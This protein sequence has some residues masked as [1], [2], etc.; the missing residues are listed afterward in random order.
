[1]AWEIGGGFG[2][3]RPLL[4]VARALAAHGHAPVFALRN[5]VEPRP[6]FAQDSFPILQAP[7]WHD[8]R[9][10][11]S[12][13]FQAASFA[14]VLAVRGWERVED[15]APQLE[16]WRDL[17]D[18]VQPRLV[19]CDHSPTL[20]LAAYGA[21]PVVQTGSWFSLP[22]LDGDSFPRMISAAEPVI[23]QEQLLAVIQQVQR[24]R[25]A[26]V[27]ARLPDFLLAT[28]RFLT[29]L[30]EV[31]AYQAVRKEQSWDPFD[32]LP[33]PA[34]V[35]AQPSF[36]AYLGADYPGVE[37]ILAQFGRTATGTVYLRGSSPPL[38]QRLRQNGLHVLDE[39]GAI[40]SLLAGASL[41]VHH[42]GIGATQTALALG[43]PQ[44]LLP[45]HLEQS[46][47]AQMLQ[48]L[49]VAAALTGP[50]KPEDAAQLFQQ[51]LGQRRFAER[52]WAVAQS[53]HARP[54]RAPL[55]AVLECCLRQLRV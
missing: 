25:Q 44:L 7:L 43:R 14:D 3:V 36:F 17:L 2:H 33:S 27:P 13:P 42:G 23:P 10:R 26:A 19:V 21:L 28:E 51:I 53:L 11:G 38:L 35:P 1:M 40:V 48:N 46:M 6:M 20:C 22:P 5:V 30:P 37:A 47:T 31:D 49:G 24:S 15:L 55:P 29:N 34:P 32:P 54:R 4:E 8:R 18:L 16:S 12:K 45:R 52:A 9:W 50:T 41:Y 39:P